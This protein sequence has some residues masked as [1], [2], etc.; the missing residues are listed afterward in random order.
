MSSRIKQKAAQSQPWNTQNSEDPPKAL[1]LVNRSKSHVCKG[2]WQ[3]SAESFCIGQIE[4]D[5]KSSPKH[6]FTSFHFSIVVFSFKLNLT[7]PQ[8]SQKWRHNIQKMVLLG[9]AQL[10]DIK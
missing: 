1:Q 4:H 9:K 6:G 3:Q 10:L 2:K 7:Q 5:S 8:H